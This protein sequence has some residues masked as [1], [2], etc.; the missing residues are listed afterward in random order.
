MIY[1]LII[2]STG[3]FL[4][5]CKIDYKHIK[6]K[7]LNYSLNIISNKNY[8]DDRFQ[9]PFFSIVG[10]NPETNKIDTFEDG[11]WFSSISDSIEI[12]DTVY[13]KKGDNFFLIKKRNLILKVKDKSNKKGE[14]IEILNR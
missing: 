5:S 1:K 14:F 11:R 10:K 13:K 9:P 12:G 3:L 2:I 7:E 8:K 6:E 4:H